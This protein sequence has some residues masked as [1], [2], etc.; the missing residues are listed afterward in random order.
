MSLQKTFCS[1][2]FVQLQ[3][4]KDNTCGPCPY[5]PN[6]WNIKGTIQEKWRAKE[7]EDLRQNF[8][9]GKKDPQCNKCWREED[10]G[11]KSLRM[12]LSEFKG[13]KNSHKIFESLIKS[14]KYLEYPRVLTLIPG[15]ECNLACPSCN[16]FLSSKWNS[17]VDNG[18]YKFHSLRKN[19]NLKDHE[20]QDIVDNSEKL[21]RIQLFGGEPFLNKKNQK[22][23]IEK[24][25]EKG[26]AKNITVYF[27]TNGTIF[28]PKYLELIT[29]NFK[30][31]EMRLSADG[32]GK[33]F[34]YLRYGA[35]WDKVCKNAEK[36]KALPNSDFEV[37]VTVS[38]FN[39][40]SLDHIDKFMS[41]REW[42]VSYNLVK[43]PSR[44]LLHNIP[45]D[46]K[47]HINLGIK[48]KDIERYTKENQCDQ[49]SWLEFVRYTNDLDKNR[50]LSFKNTF[51]ELYDVV[52]NHGYE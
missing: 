36:F 46:C 20:Y 23:L 43:Q 1:A 47:K 40:L 45:N 29:S 11:K 50:G 34:E 39:L 32:I 19:W 24:L 51:P 48:F 4:S 16:G 49:D 35:Q 31:V 3:I 12:V 8:I 13:S 2:P 9:D 10:A 33:Q 44:L 15:N 14:K 7:I 18:D 42:P 25:I 26:T 30:F 17:L 6:L 5:T 27:N 38:I 41:E 28:D 21:Q 52:K 37:N 22:L